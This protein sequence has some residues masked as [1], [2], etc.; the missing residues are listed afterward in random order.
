MVVR[1]LPVVSV[2]TRP[3]PSRFAHPYAEFLDEVEKPT[4]YLGGEYHETRKDPAA[5]PLIMKNNSPEEVQ[6]VYLYAVKLV[7]GAPVKALA[8]PE[9]AHTVWEQN[10]QLAFGATYS[11]GVRVENFNT[12]ETKQCTPSPTASN[13]S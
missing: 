4:R 2:R 13:A 8:S 7:S 10:V 12:R 11:F 6:R 1:A 3:M 5:V 9:I